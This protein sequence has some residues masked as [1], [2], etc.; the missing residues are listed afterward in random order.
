MRNF[1][2]QIKEIVAAARDNGII[3]PD[4][5]LQKMLDQL[6]NELG[7]EKKEGRIAKKAWREK[8]K[9]HAGISRTRNKQD[10]RKK[11]S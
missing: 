10:D 1:F 7:P 9:N 2:R 4:K 8:E 11:T 6:R 5:H 3:I